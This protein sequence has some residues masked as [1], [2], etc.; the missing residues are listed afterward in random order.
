MF[1]V[2]KKVYVLAFKAAKMISPSWL[3][4]KRETLWCSQVLQPSAPF[5]C[6]F[7]GFFC[8]KNKLLNHLKSLNLHLWLEQGERS[9]TAK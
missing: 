6:C 4:D 1:H 5:L 9:H 3:A 7:V 2:D 8:N